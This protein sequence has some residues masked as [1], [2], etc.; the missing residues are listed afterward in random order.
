[1]DSGGR[2]A[3]ALVQ[4]SLSR[5]ICLFDIAKKRLRSFNTRFV[6]F[7]LFT[8]IRI[9]C[10]IHWHF[11][12]FI[13]FLSLSLILSMRLDRF[14]LGIISSCSSRTEKPH[15]HTSRKKKKTPPPPL[16]QAAAPYCS[17]APHCAIRRRRRGRPWT[18]ALSRFSQTEGLDLVGGGPAAAHSERW[19]SAPVAARLGERK[20]ELEGV[21][22]SVGHGGARCGLG[23]AG[24]A[25]KRWLSDEVL[26]WRRW[27]WWRHELQIRLVQLSSIR[28]GVDGGGQEGSYSKLQKG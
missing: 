8:Q 15:T 26:R 17:S 24:E 28:L 16:L 6:G 13:P 4:A 9:G 5:E 7:D 25:P 23:S 11:D 14:A 20:K 2:R 18:A 12:L 19:G 27:K 3:S 21:R 1:M 22:D 10:L